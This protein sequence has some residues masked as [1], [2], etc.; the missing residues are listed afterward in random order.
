MNNTKFWGSAPAS[1]TNIESLPNMNNGIKKPSYKKILGSI[2]VAGVAAIA[3]GCVIALFV[4]V[5]VLRPVFALVNSTNVLKEDV[6]ALG[7]AVKNRDLI[8]LDKVIEQTRLDLDKIRQE[9]DSDLGWMRNFSYFKLSEFYSDSDKFIE[10]GFIALDAMKETSNIV[11][12]FAD[13]AGLKVNE[14]EIIDDTTGLMEAFQIWV[15]IMPEVANQMDPVIAKVDKIGEVLS[16]IDVDKYPES[17]KG[18]NIR[19]NIRFA[20]DVLSQASEYGPDIKQALIIFPGILGVDTPTKRYMI[21]M[22][23]DKEIRPTGGFMTN[24]ATF[25]MANGVLEN[26]DFSSADM[27][28]IDLVLDDIDAT[29]DFPDPPA[30]YGNYLKV[31]RW[32]ARDMNY[33]PDLPTSMDQLLVF[34]NM[35]GRI[36]PWQIKPVDAI[37]TID[38]RVIEEL[39]GVTGP[40]TVNG[41]TYNQDNVV[42]ELE[43]MASLALREQANRKGV[44]GSLMNSMLK[45]VFES[46]DKDMWPKMIDKG[47]DLAL[48]KHIQAY[49]FDPQA[50][51]LVE[52]YGLGGRIIENV[53]GDYSMVVSTNLGGD[54]T[55]WFVTKEVTHKLEKEGDRW[56]RTVSIKYDYPQPAADYDPFVKRFRDWVRVYMPQGSEIATLEGSEDGSLQGEERN[57]VWYSGYV[58]MGPAESKTLTFK[59]YLPAEIVTDKYSLTIQKQA[60]IDTEKHSVTVNGVTKELNLK[61]DT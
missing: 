21:I 4:Y 51:A 49:L 12:P 23:N 52:K 22:Q 44:L 46:T 34:Y 13:A 26:Q 7:A 11:E 37:V 35:A 45:N 25:K 33:S 15:S 57:K 53:A 56:L 27:Y 19:E 58:E 32:Y 24:F 28:S 29:Y 3:L 38:T 48:R 42:L 20:K 17:I 50:Q 6:N 31:E 43:R 60:G 8:T 16:P 61:M 41:I 30:P 39:L 2:G 1:S 54:K 5:K 59:Y 55:N 10:A 14:T 18:V 9:R 36:R 40:V 47:V